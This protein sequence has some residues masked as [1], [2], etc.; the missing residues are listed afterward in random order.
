LLTSRCTPCQAFSAGNMLA[1]QFHLEINASTVRSLTQQYAGDIST[2][3]DCV[4][5]AGEL[6]GRL[7]EHISHL[8]TTADTIYSNWLER[9]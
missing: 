4:Q 2:V 3:S 5:Q 8:H 1:M 9:L 6:C 7:D